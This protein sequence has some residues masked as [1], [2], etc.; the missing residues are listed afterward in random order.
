M[1]V[2]DT[3]GQFWPVLTPAQ[4]KRLERLRNRERPSPEARGYGPVHRALRKRLRPKVEVGLVDCA[5]CGQRILPDTPWDLGHVD[6]SNKKQWSG[7]E[8]RRCNRQT[9]LHGVKQ[10]SLPPWLRNSRD[11]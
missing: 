10:P 5:R 7:P 1:A 8:H 11:W 4:R 2:R 3:N 6:S 9:E